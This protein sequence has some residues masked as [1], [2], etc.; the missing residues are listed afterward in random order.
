[1][2]EG[3]STVRPSSDRPQ[4]RLRHWRPGGQPE[5]VHQLTKTLFAPY[6]VEGG[7]V[8]LDGCLLEEV[9][10][11]R[12]EPSDGVVRYCDRSG[13]VLAPEFA[14]SLGLD[15]LEPMPNAPQAI[16]PSALQGWLDSVLPQLPSEF[17]SETL[18]EFDLVWCRWAHGKLAFK[19]GDQSA[20]LP[21]QGWAMHWLNGENR[22]P[23]F[24]C[25]ASGR[26]SYQV[27]ATDSGQI[28]VAEAIEACAVSGQRCLESELETCSATQQRVLPKFLTSAQASGDRVL[29]SE[30]QECSTCGLSESSLRMKSDCCTL[31]QSLE[32]IDSVGQVETQ[33][34]A[35]WRQA[36]LAIHHLHNVV[37]VVDVGDSVPCTCVRN[38]PGIALVDVDRHLRGLGRT[39]ERDLVAF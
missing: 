33:D 7:A 13:Q 21:F 17:C 39:E 37:D 22:P 26:H 6:H 2:N 31:C 35:V 32:P 25:E 1:M 24:V 3:N 8:S 19:I 16:R 23:E 34:D 9:P 20:K 30:L 36:P 38:S 5:Y 11:L 12:F 14:G 27:E 4:R 10:L 29:A 28:T 15:Q 18:D